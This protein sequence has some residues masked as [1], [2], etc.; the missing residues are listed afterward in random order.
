MKGGLLAVVIA[1]IGSISRRRDSSIIDLPRLGGI[2]GWWGFLH[3]LVLIASPFVIV[4]RLLALT[5]QRIVIVI[6]H[7]IRFE[8]VGNFPYVHTLQFFAIHPRI[9]GKIQ[10][11]E[12]LGAI[13]L[14]HADALELEIDLDVVISQKGREFDEL[15]PEVLDELVVDIGDPGLQLDRDVLE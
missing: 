12:I 15:V 6:T 5:I 7:D 3:I 13:I 4:G 9:V 1:V 10:I 14:I 8:Q 2:L 11:Q